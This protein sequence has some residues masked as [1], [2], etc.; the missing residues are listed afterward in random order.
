MH[1]TRRAGFRSRRHL[2]SSPPEIQGQLKVSSRGL[3]GH[4]FKKRL[5]ALGVHGSKNHRYVAFKLMHVTRNLT[6]A[7]VRKH[8]RREPASRKH[9]DQALHAAPRADLMLRVRQNASPITL[10]TFACLNHV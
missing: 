4:T 2:G 8:F 1:L 5:D 7:L 6:A 10:E 3:G 9:T